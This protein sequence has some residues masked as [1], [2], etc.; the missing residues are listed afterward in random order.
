MYKRALQLLQLLLAIFSVY[1][2]L[3]YSSN[4]QKIVPLICLIAI[5]VIEK[6]HDRHTE[7]ATSP[8]Q[9]KTNHSA[10][11]KKATIQDQFNYLLRSRNPV[12][13]SDSAQYL[14]HNLGLQ[15]S[16]T[17]DSKMISWIVRGTGNKYFIGLLIV[18]DI[19][20]TDSNWSGWNQVGEY[21][22]RYGNSYRTLVIWSN[23]VVSKN[24]K[25]RFYKFPPQIIEV[26]K[27]KNV[28]A[29]STYTLFQLY[30]LCKSNRLDVHKVFKTI[31]QYPSGVFSLK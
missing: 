25:M 18:M 15:V 3:S 11:E 20:K 23:G 14:L 28:V 10:A 5:Y 27:E 1:W 30:R 24:D 16:K 22:E 8:E 21:A 12:L 4:L 26:I 7:Q 9:Q 29:V 31:Q 19:L 17:S 6:L 13:I 2:L